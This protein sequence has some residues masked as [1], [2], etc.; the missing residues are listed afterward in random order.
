MP[1]SGDPRPLFDL[2]QLAVNAALL[3]V[4]AYFST[5][6]AQSLLTGRHEQLLPAA[7]PEARVTAPTRQ[8]I[9]TGEMASW[10]LFGEVDTP[11]P[12]RSALLSGPETSLNLNLR[13]IVN[14]DDSGAQL[15]I[16]QDNDA[17]TEWYFAIGETVFGLAR[18]EE[19]YT[20]RVIISREGRYETLRLPEERLAG[21]AVEPASVLG[22]RI[23]SEAYVSFMAAQM[24]DIHRKMLESERNPWR[25]VY[26]E[27]VISGSRITG[28]RLAA[29]EETEFLARYGLQLGDVIT[30][31]NGQALDAGGGLL[32]ALDLVSDV[33]ELRFV[34]E[35]NG[36]EQT[37]KVRN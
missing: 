3:A 22:K 37:I 12:Q 17:L 20:D 14:S 1:T 32:K 26:Y 2:V 9:D 31:I 10:H 16:I 5:Q 15:A 35:R 18:L 33:E 21:M 6:L 27:P 34:I 13:G 30:S 25:Y 11:R 19:I 23:S 8:A 28:L 29:E 4:L 36:T 7:L 24:R